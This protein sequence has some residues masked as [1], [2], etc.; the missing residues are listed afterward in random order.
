M[1]S[2][3]GAFRLPTKEAGSVRKLGHAGLWLLLCPPVGWLMALGYRGQAAWRL[4]DGERKSRP[5]RREE[6]KGHRGL[7]GLGGHP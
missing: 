5:G 1:L 4:V 2:W 3:Q 6:E 7:L